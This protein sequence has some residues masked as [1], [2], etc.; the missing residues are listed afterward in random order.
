MF[1]SPAG[2]IFHCRDSAIKFLQKTVGKNI[3]SPP[4]SSDLQPT[5]FCQIQVDASDSSVVVSDQED[6]E[7][8]EDTIS[9]SDEELEEPPKKRTKCEK[10]PG[11]PIGA[12]QEEILVGCY[13]E[14]PHPTTRVVSEIVKDTGLLAQVII[15]WYGDRTRNIIENILCKDK[16]S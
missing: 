6:Q 5:D 8:Q 16:S 4:A 2:K 10:M 14:W 11:E 9:L 13:S 15:S 3:P 1:Y 12:S 7:D